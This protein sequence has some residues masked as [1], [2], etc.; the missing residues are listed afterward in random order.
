MKPLKPVKSFA[1]LFDAKG[2][3]PESL[4]WGYGPKPFVSCKKAKLF[5][6]Y[7]GLIKSVLLLI[8]DDWEWFDSISCEEILTGSDSK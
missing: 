4:L 7:N 5:N 3:R 1:F 2:C 8:D 6:G